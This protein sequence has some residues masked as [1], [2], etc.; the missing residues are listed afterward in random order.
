M[1]SL[2]GVPKRNLGIRNL[3]A[4]L[5]A[6]AKSGEY[7][8][9]GDG[10]IGTNAA[11]SGTQ[12]SYSNIGEVI[13]HYNALK[14]RTI[15]RDEERTVPTGVSNQS[16]YLA[17]LTAL[18]AAD[19]GGDVKGPGSS[20]D[21]AIVRFDGV[22]GKLIQNS[23]VTIADGGGSISVNANTFSFITSNGRFGFRNDGDGLDSF[24][25]QNGN[26]LVFNGGTTGGSE[27]VKLLS[28]SDGILKIFGRGGVDAEVRAYDSAGTKYGVL[29]PY[30]L[31]L[32]S[33]DISYT[34]GNAGD[35]N[36]SISV[37]TGVFEALDEL[38]AVSGNG[39][40][41]GASQDLE[42]VLIQG[43]DANNQ[44]I[45]GLNSLT[46]DNSTNSVRVEPSGFDGK[47]IIY[48]PNASINARLV[49]RNEISGGQ[50]TI[51]PVDIQTINSD[52][53]IK[54]GNDTRAQIRTSWTEI[55]DELRVGTQNDYSYLVSNQLVLL[56]GGDIKYYP[57]TPSV[58]SGSASTPT[59][60][61]EALD[62]L[63]AVSGQGS[64]TLTFVAH[65]ASGTL[66][67]SDM[68]GQIHTNRGA[69]S[70]IILTL[71]SASGGLNATF[72]QSASGSIEIA[73]QSGDVI[74]RTSGDLSAGQS[75][76][77]QNELSKLYIGSDGNGEWF[78]IDEAGTVME[79]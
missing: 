73:P 46:F 7:N 18:L 31:T 65:T 34:P 78:I 36:G 35:W 43:S 21:N 72:L 69:T 9:P 20:T 3:G 33:G 64:S 15:E 23:D 41:G 66:S 4:Y 8:I 39:G 52:F 62:E 19:A 17:T 37:P 70:G 27:R 49:L 10:T 76:Q 30:E 58:W 38:V 74:R 61:F 54:R 68:E 79:I 56:D 48:D 13:K 77:L 2:G 26:S 6:T 42:S 1:G 14:D 12:T 60:V 71:P 24:Q 25:I 57:G 51:S 55:R 5:S 22:T 45:I 50:T 40:G 67:S 44:S 63:A 47:L 32:A 11:E 75:I 53:L 59:G 29:T 28:D 16:S